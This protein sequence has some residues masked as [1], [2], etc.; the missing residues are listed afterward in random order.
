MSID[1][2]IWINLGKNLTIEYYTVMKINKLLLHVAT[3]INHT[4]IMLNEKGQTKMY[5]PHDSMYINFKNK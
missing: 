5:T 4:N 2:K 3:W 1:S